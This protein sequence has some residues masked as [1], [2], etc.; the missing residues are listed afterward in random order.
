MK[1]IILVIFIAIFG[2]I[3]VAPTVANTTFV[4]EQKKGDKRG[5]KK[6]DPPGPANVRPK[7]RERERPAEKPRDRGGK[8]GKGKKPGND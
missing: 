1:R 3:S 5:D 8:S 4:Y 2:M 6:K 7:E